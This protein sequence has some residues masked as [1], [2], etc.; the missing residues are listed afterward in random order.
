[1][2]KGL[3]C[4]AGSGGAASRQ[5]WG[6][7]AQEGVGG[8]SRRVGCCAAAHGQPLAWPGP[9]CALNLQQPLDVPDP[10]TPHCRELLRRLLPASLPPL[11]VGSRGRDSSVCFH[12]CPQQCPVP[13]SALS[14]HHR[15]S[16]LQKANLA[17]GRALA[18]VLCH[19]SH[20]G[21]AQARSSLQLCPLPGRGFPY[22]RTCAH[23][24]AALL[25]AGACRP[26]AKAG[27]AAS[28][29]KAPPPRRISLEAERGP[30][31]GRG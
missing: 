26:D 4:P 11:K 8:G 19:S 6:P 13:S 23:L 2:G 20:W 12:C 25:G 14:E 21:Q 9:L 18:M 27:T 5:V 15:D 10:A 30:A 29:M 28:G 16:G 31:S 17:S 1:M 24:G 3:G 7:T 22:A